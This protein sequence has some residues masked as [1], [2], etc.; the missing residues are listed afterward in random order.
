[1][2]LLGTGAPVDHAL[3]LEWLERAAELGDPLAM[4]I[5]GT[6]S[7]GI[8]GG[9]AFE[10]PGVEYLERAIALGSDLA[11][12]VL[13]LRL[14]DGVRAPRDPERGFR[15][16]EEA[17]A[18][19]L[20]LALFYLGHKLLNLPGGSPEVRRRGLRLLRRVARDVPGVQ[21]YLARAYEMGLGTRRDLV[22]AREMNR[23]GAELGDPQ[24]MYRYALYLGDGVGGPLRPREGL[25]WMAMA[26]ERGV[27]KALD[28]LRSLGRRPPRGPLAGPD[29]APLPGHDPDPP[30][31]EGAALSRPP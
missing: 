31:S 2:R 30:A 16:L 19:H 3:A 29:E 28:H 1:M 14:F 25:R 8:R 24:A 22:K 5:V 17:A 6:M 23:R 4:A 27:S 12:V 20:P 15:L 21:A 10:T 7:P 26:A 11:R 18:N 13:G 9:A